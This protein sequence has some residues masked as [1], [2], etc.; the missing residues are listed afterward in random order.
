MRK[1]LLL[2][3]TLCLILAAWVRRWLRQ[4]GDHQVVH[5]VLVIL[6]CRRVCRATG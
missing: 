1:I 2:P 5:D 3:I 6:R 4:L